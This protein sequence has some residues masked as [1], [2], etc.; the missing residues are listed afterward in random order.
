MSVT[1]QDGL[2]AYMYVQ[3]VAYAVR[4]YVD[5]ILTYLL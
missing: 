2:I 4:Y 5:I 1:G 3:F